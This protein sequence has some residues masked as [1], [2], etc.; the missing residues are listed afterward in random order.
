MDITCIPTR[1]VRRTGFA[2]TSLTRAE[3]IILHPAATP[4]RD[5][6]PHPRWHGLRCTHAPQSHPLPRGT[7]SSKGE[8]ALQTGGNIWEVLGLT[9]EERS[10]PRAIPTSPLK[11]ARWAL[12]GSVHAWFG[13]DEQHEGRRAQP[14]PSRRSRPVAPGRWQ[15]SPTDA[16]ARSA[17]LPGRLGA[18]SISLSLVFRSFTGNGFIAR[19]LSC[20]SP[21]GGFFSY[22]RESCEVPQHGRNA[23]ITESGRDHGTRIHTCAYA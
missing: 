18:S 13:K 17:L 21:T 6:D 4:H 20:N 5:R 10:A 8:R 16:P 9:R 11:S 19:D 14:A 7:Q 23:G 1:S 15:C 22:G 12:Q 3:G 2:V